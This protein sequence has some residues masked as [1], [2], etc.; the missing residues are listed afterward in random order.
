MNPI[1]LLAALLLSIGSSTQDPGQRPRAAPSDRFGLLEVNELYFD[2]AANTGGDFYFWAPGEFAKSNLQIPIHDED[3]VLAYGRLDG[4]TRNFSIPV[5]S[6]AKTLTIFS[7]IQ[8]K[9]IVSIIRPDGSVLAAGARGAK[10]QSF[11]YMTI[12]TV[13]A[14]EPGAWRVVL[15]GAGKYAVTAHVRAANDASAPGFNDFEFVQLGGRPAHEG[16]F[17]IQ[18]D[19]R[20]GETIECSTEVSGRVSGAEF[21]FVTRDDRLIASVPMQAEENGDNYFGRCQI[22]DIPFRVAVSGRDEQGRPFRRIESGL[23]TP[24]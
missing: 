10:L 15:S 23:N 14:P 16:W 6:G 22:P 4:P 19:L 9:D 13:D 21:A 11:R 20:K 24:K 12:A 8:R 1:A 3:V 7:G 18:R 2:L 5:E 17:P